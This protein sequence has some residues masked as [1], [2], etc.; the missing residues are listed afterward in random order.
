MAEFFPPKFLF[1]WFR[2]SSGGKKGPKLETLGI[3]RFCKDLNFSKILKALFLFPW[4]LTVVKTLAIF[5]GVRVQNLP[6]KGYFMDAW[7]GTKNFKIYNLTTKNAILTKLTTIIYL[8]ETFHLQK[9][10]GRNSQGVRRHNWKTS[11]SK[12]ENQFFGLI[13]WNFQDFTKNCNMSCTSLLVQISKNL[14]TFRGVIYEKPPKN[15]KNGML[16]KLS[17]FM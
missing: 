12:S 2:P 9:K 10:L 13:S 17:R 14:T 6:K 5:G 15:G 8:Y 3:S 16:M 7:I 11:E 1:L 4:I